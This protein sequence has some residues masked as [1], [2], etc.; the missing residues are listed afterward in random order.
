MAREYGPDPHADLRELIFSDV[1]QLPVTNPH[2]RH[3]RRSSIVLER[4]CDQEGLEERIDGA[5]RLIPIE[6]CPVG[7]LE[8]E[9]KLS[10]GRL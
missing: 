2:G 5:V 8:G 10:I 6:D 3:T 9:V 7:S 4:A 1:R